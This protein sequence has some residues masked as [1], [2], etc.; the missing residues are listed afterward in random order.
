MMHVFSR[1]EVTEVITDD[2]IPGGRDPSC[3]SVPV[4]QFSPLSWNKIFPFSLAVVVSI[5]IPRTMGV[6]RRFWELLQ[7][8]LRPPN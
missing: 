4:S 8:L 3:P 1:E 6:C 2:K 7:A 5:S